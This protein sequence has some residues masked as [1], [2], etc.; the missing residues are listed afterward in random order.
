MRY[1]RR[2]SSITLAGSQTARGRV[3][4]GSSRML[5]HT[6]SG[7]RG[8]LMTMAGVRRWRCDLQGLPAVQLR[9]TYVDEGEAPRGQQLR[10]LLLLLLCAR[11]VGDV[12]GPRAVAL[13]LPLLLQQLLEAAWR[14]ILRVV[15]VHTCH[16]AGSGAR[17][18]HVVQ[19]RHRALP[20]GVVEDE[21]LLA[22]CR[23]L[24]GRRTCGLAH[25]LLHLAVV[26]ASHL[27][28]VLEVLDPRGPG[29]Q[30]EAH[31][32][33]RGLRDQAACVVHPYLRGCVQVAE[34][35]AVLGTDVPADI[36][37]LHR[38][39]IVEH[40]RVPRRL[41]QRARGS[42]WGRPQRRRGQSERVATGCGCRA[43]RGTQ[44][45][46]AFLGWLPRHSIITHRGCRPLACR[47]WP[48][49]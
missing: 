12:Q 17:L 37:A 45:P 3:C 31:A 4:N 5:R 24:R 13:R 40:H 14:R 23:R 33:E 43:R 22:A 21:H 2:S 19:R 30:L 48:Y 26:H 6:C 47:P 32:L 25:Q 36:F 35:A 11:V 41:L 8:A 34:R 16:A 9:F 27:G 18:V 20:D 38:L 44:H 39:L 29:A 1:R 15:A 49:L 28:V 42:D 7:H 10:G 46:V